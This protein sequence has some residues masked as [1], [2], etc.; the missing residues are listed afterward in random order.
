MAHDALTLEALARSW[1][2]QQCQTVPSIRR[3]LV[4]LGSSGG[5]TVTPTAFWPDGSRGTPGLSAAAKLA[6]SRKCPVVRGKQGNGDGGAVPTLEVA[7]PI[8]VEG[9]LFGV[10]AVE[11]ESPGEQQQRAVMQ[12][13]QWGSTWLEFLVQRETS[14]VTG[15]L[16]TVLEMVAMVVEHEHF[17]AAATAAATELASRLDCERVSLGFLSG[18]HMRVCALSHSAQFGKKTN[19]IR[20]IGTAMDEALDQDTIMVFPPPADQRTAITKAHAHLARRHGEHVICTIP[21]SEA[22]RIIG[23]ITLERL[24]EREFDRTSV[25]LCEAIVSLLGP[26]L[27]NKR[28]HDRWFGAKLAEGFTKFTK[29][30]LG[31]RHPGLKLAAAGL[32]GLVAFLSFA[33][34]IYR[35]SAPATLEGAIQRA[36]VAPMDGYIASAGLRAGDLVGEGHVL[37][38]LDDRDLTLERVKWSSQREQLVKEYRSALATHDRTQT[39]ILS[40]QIAQAEAQVALL[41]EQLART[42]ITAPFEGV[43]VSGDLSQALG[44][45]VERGE[46]L[47]ELAPFDAYRVI[48]E[49]DEREIS[50]IEEGGR[51]HLALSSVPDARFPLVVERITPVSKVDRGRNFFRVEARLEEQPPYLRP[52]MQ[53]IG[54]IDI[55][56]RSLA[57]IWTHELRD[58][59]RLHLWTWWA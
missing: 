40:A 48:L 23:V 57:W 56:R 50:V 34:G 24:P 44:S 32:I 42:Q 33:T 59:L 7:C 18:R 11:V 37:G 13:L 46:V 43:I 51:G 36:I 58:W 49:V 54:K 53:G 10:V 19:L 45:P 5:G 55:E 20:D 22:G 21:F 15:R 9:E 2:A 17:Q 14:A 27:E 47:F 16:V 8:L 29:R 28:K 52:G 6:M 26:I 38:T 35:V 39:R 25:E 3:G 41:D 4:M 12:L 31:P 1:L 30:L